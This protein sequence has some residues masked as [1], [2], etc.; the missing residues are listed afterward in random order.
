MKQVIL[1]G[2]GVYSKNILDFLRYCNMDKYIAALCE[3]SLD[4]TRKIFFDKPVISYEEAKEKNLSF[5]ISVSEKW[6]D[7]IQHILEQD[8]V[9]YFDGITQ[10]LQL[11]FRDGFTKLNRDY[12]AYFHIDGMDEYFEIAESEDSLK[13]FWSEDSAFY[14]MFTQLNLD[15]VIELAC[16][17]GRHVN[18]YYSKANEIML[19]DV[20][21]K[22]IQ[23]CK[24]RFG[25]RKNI[26]YY[27]NN[28]FDLS[29]LS[30]ESYS[31]LFTYDAMVHFE[32]FDI[33]NYLKETYR[34]LI[35]D[36]LALFHHSNLASDYRQTFRN[37]GNPGGRNFMSK[38][39]FAYL[40]Y[41]AGFEIVEQQVID[42]SLPSMDCIT[43]VK[44]S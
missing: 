12:C 5:V 17:R 14:K 20:L 43:L 31:A 22:N 28:G 19:V 36:G 40:A 7:E 26:K 33:Y 1:Y 11:E 25:N 29:E 38:E 23:F 2:A 41:K 18:Q 16:G 9:K 27:Q 10:W 3:S 37:S 13:T 35:N 34:V 8:G 4:E 42:W 24:D 15:R 39:L 44:K 21:A 30:N 32:M 6:R